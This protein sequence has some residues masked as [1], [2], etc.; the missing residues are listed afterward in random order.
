METPLAVQL[1][2][3]AGLAALA[4]LLVREAEAT[5]AVSAAEEEEKKK[6]HQAA[7]AKQ[8]RGSPIKLLSFVGVALRLSVGLLFL[9][10]REVVA[11]AMKA[12]MVRARAAP[13]VAFPSSQAALEASCFVQLLALAALLA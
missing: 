6:N 10:V 11:P 5:T 9:A 3:L 12:V 7:E 2:A 1:L 4:G 13:A 8:Q